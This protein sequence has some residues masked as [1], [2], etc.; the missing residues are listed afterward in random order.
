LAVALFAV[1][2]TTGID[3]G[4]AVMGSLGLP[5]SSIGVSS[6]NNNNHTNNHHNLQNI[7]TASNNNNNNIMNNNNNQNGNN[8]NNN[9]HRS[10]SSINTNYGSMPP[11]HTAMSQ[12]Q[13]ASLRPVG[14]LN[15]NNTENVIINNNQQPMFYGDQTNTNANNNNQHSQVP[16][17]DVTLNPHS[18][19][20]IKKFIVS[21]RSQ[22]EPLT[23]DEFAHIGLVFAYEQENNNNNN[24]G[25]S[26]SGLVPLVQNGPNVPVTSSNFEEFCRL[27]FEAMNRIENNKVGQT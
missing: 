16:T 22:I 4:D 10:Q 2:T 23:D 15:N 20:N 8:N 21:I 6:S 1:S 5:S 13:H 26:F 25:S 7:N 17:G 24:G 12:S 3:L 27:F 9:N 14:A 11:F 18:I 19:S